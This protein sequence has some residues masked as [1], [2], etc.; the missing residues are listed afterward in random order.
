MTT[1]QKY[2]KAI[3]RVMNEID[4]LVRSRYPILYLLSHEERRVESLLA[5]LAQRQKKALMVW[6]ATQGLQKSN[7]Q[8][9]V[10]V[11][12]RDDEALVDPAELIKKIQ[13][14]EQE[15]IYFL[16]DF[17]PF[18]DD[19]HVVRRLRDAAQKLRDSFKTIVICSPTLNLPQELEKEVTLIDVP[20]PDFYELYEL[21]AEVC[22]Q[23]GK[24]NPG[25]VKLNTEEGKLMARAAQG[26]TLA[27]AEN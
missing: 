15:G 10:Q 27:E 3:D 21:L 6:T 1:P 13:E 17:H 19:P 23:L 14:N 20:L 12:H 4:V 26:L 25:T 9:E 24:T 18:L 7:E 22:Q 16:K 8:V 5:E 2:V 11:A